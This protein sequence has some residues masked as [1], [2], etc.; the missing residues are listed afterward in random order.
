MND[1]C[2]QAAHLATVL[3]WVLALSALAVLIVLMR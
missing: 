1:V 3:R 2:G